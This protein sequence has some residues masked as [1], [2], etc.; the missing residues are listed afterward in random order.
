MVN[1]NDLNTS[2][3]Y[4]LTTLEVEDNSPTGKGL[5]ALFH[6]STMIYVSQCGA[7]NKHGKLDRDI[8]QRLNQFVNLD[9]GSAFLK[10]YCKKF[11]CNVSDIEFSTLII[12]DSSKIR[13]YK[14][15]AIKHFNVKKYV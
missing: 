3:R 4:K 7:D 12:S 10:N 5:I 13:D 1:L 9:T 15:Q 8:K 6:N 2:K 14:D 11:K